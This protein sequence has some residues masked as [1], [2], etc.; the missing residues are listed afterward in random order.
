MP[1]VFEKLLSDLMQA[2]RG[3]LPTGCLPLSC[4]GNGW[5]AAIGRKSDPS[6]CRERL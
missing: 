5:E 3:G 2:L 4:R 1:G 6:P